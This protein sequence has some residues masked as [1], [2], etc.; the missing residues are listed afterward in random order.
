MHGPT[1]RIVT[2]HGLHAIYNGT[3]KRETVTVKKAQEYMG[4]Y[5]LARKIPEFLWRYIYDKIQY[6]VID[7]KPS[8]L[9]M[10]QSKA[11][12]QLADSTNRHCANR[13]H[14]ER[15][16]AKRYHTERHHSKRH[17]A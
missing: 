15:H 3:C 6:S 11:E 1:V 4:A 5:H 17:N 16:H 2:T 8:K 9:Y 10:H 7:I 12:W 14:A 13:H